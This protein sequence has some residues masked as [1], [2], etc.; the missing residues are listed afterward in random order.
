M[1]FFLAMSSWSLRSEIVVFE[2]VMCIKTSM[3]RFVCMFLLISCVR[4]AVEEPQ[5]MLIHA[6]F[7]NLEEKNETEFQTFQ[8]LHHSVN[9]LVQVFNTFSFV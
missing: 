4:F 6:G 2:Q 5:V 7:N 8:V 9:S 3:P 1:P